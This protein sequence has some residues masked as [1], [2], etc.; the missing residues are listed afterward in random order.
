MAK[1]QTLLRLENFSHPERR[2]KLQEKKKLS[3]FLVICKDRL[4]L[5]MAQINEKFRLLK[6]TH[7]LWEIRGLAVK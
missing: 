1:I 3:H 5:N 7:R 4:K 2:L 6:A